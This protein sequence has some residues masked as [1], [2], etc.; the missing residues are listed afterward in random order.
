MADFSEE[1]LFRLCGALL[2]MAFMLI[3]VLYIYYQR[4]NNKLLFVCANLFVLLIVSF[5][6]FS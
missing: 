5:V 2:G 1:P 6:V 3:P 4:G